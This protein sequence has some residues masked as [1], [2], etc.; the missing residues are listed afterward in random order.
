MTC[1]ERSFQ[2]V[3][4][5]DVFEK[6]VGKMEQSKISALKEIQ[7]AVIDYLPAG[8]EPTTAEQLAHTTYL[9]CLRWLE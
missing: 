4:V 9:I 1:G 8:V 3:C 2:C 5:L 7:E 6:I